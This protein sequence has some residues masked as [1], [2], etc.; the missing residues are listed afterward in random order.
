MRRREE[1][2]LP[3][4]RLIILCGDLHSDLVEIIHRSDDFILYIIAPD[5]VVKGGK[6]VI[7][8]IKFIEEENISP[9]KIRRHACQR[10][11]GRRIEVGVK[12]EDPGYGGVIG[13]T[14]VVAQKFI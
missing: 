9:A 8:D 1:I 6:F 12:V 14:A 7:G 11:K 13:V 5:K 4:C 10:E 3:G 2:I